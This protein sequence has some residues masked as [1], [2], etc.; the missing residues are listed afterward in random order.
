MNYAPGAGSLARSVDYGRPMRQLGS[1]VLARQK[2]TIIAINDPIMWWL[3]LWVNATTL[4]L[5]HIM[6]YNVN[7]CR[8]GQ[9]GPND[10][11]KIHVHMQN[12]DN[13]IWNGIFIC[14]YGSV[15]YSVFY[16]AV[17][18]NICYNFALFTMVCKHFNDKCQIKGSRNFQVKRQ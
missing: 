3:Y 9:Y 2:Q 16:I 17:C 18:A 6:K 10:S 12:E 1:L 11:S 13:Y 15:V 5:I 4:P 8:C 7:D 14:M